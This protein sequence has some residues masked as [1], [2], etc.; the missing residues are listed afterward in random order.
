MLRPLPAA[1]GP[2]LLL[3]AATPATATLYIVH[4]GGLGDPATIQD[5]IDLAWPGDVIGLA[6]G[7]FQGP[8]NCCF[9]FLGKA[10][11]VQSLSGNPDA[12]ILDGESVF[13]PCWPI[14]VNFVS[15]EGP[16][17]VLEG[18][19]LFDF[20]DGPPDI[21]GSGAIRIDG[22]SPTLRNVVVRQS[23]F[24]DWYRFAIYAT[25][26]DPQIADCK[27]LDNRGGA[28]SFRG[29]GAVI[30]G[31]ILSASSG[32]ETD[33]ASIECWNS[34]LDIRST[35]VRLGQG[36]NMTGGSLR[37]EGCLVVDNRGIAGAGL[38]VN[39]GTVTILRSTFAGNCA[40]TGGAIHAVGAAISLDQSIL[41]ANE[42]TSTAPAVWLGAGSSMIASCTDLDPSG[43]AGSGIF[44]PGPGFVTV[45]PSFCDVR[46]CG[47]PWTDEGL[48]SLPAFSPARDVPGCG[49]LGAVYGICTTAVEPVTWGRV[50]ARWRTP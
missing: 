22:S 21:G 13:G 11:T 15:G 40:T 42:A 14:G 8:G 48:Y 3:S 10:V 32:G 33:G 26:A 9:D 27:F 31:C 38:R 2:I 7:T 46:V 1:L 12:C 44:T 35:A 50:K 30:T 25:D 23:S 49:T 29:G 19:T 34:D 28:L 36:I 45:D 37:L 47:R 6:D 4:P 20:Y 39:G 43:I 18:V 17:S 41:W 5:A 16:G 24:G